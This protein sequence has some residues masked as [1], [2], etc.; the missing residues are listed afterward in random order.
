MTTA[1]ANSTAKYRMLLALACDST[2][3]SALSLETVIAVCVATE[4]DYEAAKANLL[5]QA[6]IDPGQ[7]ED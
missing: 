3:I 2:A 6:N 5:S 4:W 7:T 1:N